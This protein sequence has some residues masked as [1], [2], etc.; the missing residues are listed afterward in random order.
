MAM[1]RGGG[2]AT[3]I[4]VCV[5][6][7]GLIAA[8]RLGY[9]D[10]VQGKL[11]P[12]TLSKVRLSAGDFPAGVAAPVA[13]IASIPLR[14]T[15][16]GFSP[17]GSASALLLATGGAATPDVKRAPSGLLKTRYALDAQAIVFANEGDLRQALAYG[18]DNGGVDMAALSVSQL[19]RWGTALRDAAPRTVLLLG[20]SRGQDAL[21]GVGIER[22]SD[23]K[24]KRLAVARQGG[25]DYFAL[26]LLSRAGLNFNDVRWVDVDK[27]IDAGPALREGRADAAVGLYADVSLAARD[28]G[29]KVLASTTDAPHLLANVL[30]VR[31][32]FAARYP[33]AVRRVIRA[34]LDSA[35]IVRR[36]PYEGA[37]L[38]GE[39]APYLGDP[40]EAIASAPPAVLSENLAFFG[41]VGEAP[42]TYDELYQSASSLYMKLEKLSVPPPP[43]D[44]TRN[45]GPLRYVSEAHG[46]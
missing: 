11:F 24:G 4:G 16:I 35:A 2:L 5:L 45:L 20:R 30:V 31:G 38:L 25:A 26:W 19:A 22:V 42:V 36:E 28:R 15:R 39:V 33:D 7:V 41:I 29:G 17:R 1:R 27:T 43:V 40:T 12:E 18:A 37:K 9:I 32:E 8:S 44:D 3:F 13:E 21:A 46:P 10:W 23:L 14:P 6:A 34:L